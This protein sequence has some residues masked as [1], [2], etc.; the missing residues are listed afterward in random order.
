MQIFLIQYL[1]KYGKGTRS[2][3]YEF[4]IS[5]HAKKFFAL[6]Q[7]LVIVFEQNSKKHN[8]PNRFSPNLQQLREIITTYN[9]ENTPVD[10]ALA[11][12]NA[13]AFEGY[14]YPFQVKRFY[15]KPSDKTNLELAKLSM[16]KQ[17]NIVRAM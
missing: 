11:P 10:F 4:A 7:Q 9:E 12:V 2:K 8:Y 15:C 13:N 5:L 16:R 1:Q 17:S 14:A 6:N 3:D